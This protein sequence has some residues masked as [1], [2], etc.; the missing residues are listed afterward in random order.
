MRKGGLEGRGAPSISR[1]FID[2]IMTLEM[3]SHFAGSHNPEAWTLHNPRVAP[4]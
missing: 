3:L 1:Y 2:V 4:F